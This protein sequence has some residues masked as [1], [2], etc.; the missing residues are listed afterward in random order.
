MDRRDGTLTW[1]SLPV[2]KL[3]HVAVRLVPILVIIAAFYYIASSLEMKFASIS[4][5]L[6][7]A[8]GAFADWNFAETKELKY[9][10]MPDFFMQDDPTTDAAAFDYVCYHPQPVLT[11]TDNKQAQW[12][13]GLVNRTYPTDLKN[14]RKGYETQWERFAQYVKHLNRNTS[15]DKTRY[16]VLVMGRHGEGWHN[17]AESYYGTPAWNVGNSFHLKSIH[18]Q[19]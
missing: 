9:T 19:I 17:A 8:P 3:R 11:H 10:S 2:F 5:L 7:L 1:A 16:K 13:L 6:A 14:P 15:R 12:N 18:L 4:T